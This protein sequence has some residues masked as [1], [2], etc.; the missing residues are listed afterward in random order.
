ML[1]IWKLQSVTKQA[2][3]NSKSFFCTGRAAAAAGRVFLPSLLSFEKSTAH[4]WCRLDVMGYILLYLRVLFGLQLTCSLC[5]RLSLA[6]S[7]KPLQSLSPSSSV[8]KV[9]WLSRKSPRRS[10]V[11]WLNIH[12]GLDCSESSSLESSI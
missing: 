7:C 12:K 5:S 3:T 6:R 2:I 4:A 8:F 10:R 1:H 9:L 11:A